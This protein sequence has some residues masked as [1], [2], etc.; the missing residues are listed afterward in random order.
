MHKNVLVKLIA[1]DGIAAEEEFSTR[2]SVTQPQIAVTDLCVFSK[3][4]LKVVIS[5]YLSEQ[6]I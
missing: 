6:V 3:V 5:V 1:S 2:D 4:A